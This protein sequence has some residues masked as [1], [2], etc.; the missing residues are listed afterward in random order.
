MM[1]RVFRL[2]FC[3]PRR[4]TTQ[5]CLWLSRRGILPAPRHSSSKTRKARWSPHTPN[6]AIQ[7]SGGGSLFDSG[8]NPGHL[9]F[10]APLICPIHRIAFH[11]FASYFPY[12]DHR[13]WKTETALTM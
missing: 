2:L 8:D 1:S 13:F 10:H 7:G 9:S 12:P 11:A 3:T 4:R 6:P 5:F